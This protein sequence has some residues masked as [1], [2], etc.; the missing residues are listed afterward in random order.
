MCFRRR[1]KAALSGPPHTHTH[2]KQSIFLCTHKHTV[3]VPLWNTHFCNRPQFFWYRWKG[4]A[5]QWHPQARTTMFLYFFK[6]TLELS[7][8]YSTEMA[9]SLV[10]AQHGFGTFSGFIRCTWKKETIL[11]GPPATFFPSF[12]LGLYSVKHFAPCVIFLR[13]RKR[14][15]PVTSCHV[16][17]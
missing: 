2:T 1:G 7:S 13:R 8:K 4:S 14:A 3:T 16:T 5:R 17:L 9:W 6:M 11:K 15:Y 12:Q 10:G